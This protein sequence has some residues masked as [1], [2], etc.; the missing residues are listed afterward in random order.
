MVTKSPVSKQPPTKR[1]II[2]SAQVKKFMKVSTA[3]RQEQIMMKS[4]LHCNVAT[5]L[6][7]VLAS[8][9]IMQI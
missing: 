6:V 5:H 9:A 4:T 8:D 2:K 1:I 7:Y 3:D